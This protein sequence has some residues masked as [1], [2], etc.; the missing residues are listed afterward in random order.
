[1]DHHVP[2]STPKAQFS[3]A[4]GFSLPVPNYSAILSYAVK[5]IPSQ[6]P[7]LEEECVLPIPARSLSRLQPRLYHTSH[8]NGADCVVIIVKHRYDNTEES[9]YLWHVNT[10]SISNGILFH[11]ANN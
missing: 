8:G 9:T 6:V 2:P 11:P 3:L 1:M 5:P 7:K 10:Y 4:A